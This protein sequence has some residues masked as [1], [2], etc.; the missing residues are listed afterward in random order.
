MRRFS[1]SSRSQFASRTSGIEE[2]GVGQGYRPLQLPDPVLRKQDHG[3]VRAHLLD[4]SAE[5]SLQEADRVGL[6]VLGV[7]H[8]SA[9]FRKTIGSA[10]SRDT[11]RG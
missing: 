2:V 8:E 6:A 4:L 1:A 3:Q 7:G 10:H 11:R 5:P 9:P